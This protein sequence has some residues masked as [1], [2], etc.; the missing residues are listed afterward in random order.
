MGAER[1]LDW[2]ERTELPI[3]ATTSI[4]GL[5]DYLEEELF[6]PTE[7]QLNA[8]W[9]A[10]GFKYETLAPIGIRPVLVTFP[11]GEELRFGVKGRPGLW[12]LE[13]VMG[14]LEEEE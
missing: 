5:Q 10:V 8:L 3:S 12:G 13:S 11:W 2:L 7:R 14:F 9:D 4:R 1:Y 6:T